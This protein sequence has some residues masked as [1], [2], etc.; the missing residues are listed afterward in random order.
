MTDTSKKFIHMED[1]EDGSLTITYSCGDLF[2]GVLSDMTVVVEG[3]IES[4]L[5]AT[6][7]SVTPEQIESI[8]CDATVIPNDAS[9][10]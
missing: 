8:G 3:T 5:M 1:N 9:S 10:A 2:E 6:L 4:F 7:Q